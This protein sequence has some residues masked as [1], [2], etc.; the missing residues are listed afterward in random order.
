MYSATEGETSSFSSESSVPVRCFSINRLF[1]GCWLYIF[2][3]LGENVR[4]SCREPLNNSATATLVQ[5]CFS[6]LIKIIMEGKMGIALLKSKVIDFYYKRIDI[7]YYSVL[8]AVVLENTPKRCL[9][10]W[11][12]EVYFLNWEMFYCD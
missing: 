10:S 8:K 11:K 4:H 3:D 9:R 7:M 2:V 5:K 1:I 6:C 12:T